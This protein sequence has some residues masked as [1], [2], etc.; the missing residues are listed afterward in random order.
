MAGNLTV[1][2][3]LREYKNKVN[4]DVWFHS[5]NLSSYDSSAQVAGDEKNVN[6]ISG[7]SD[8]TLSLFLE[9][10]GAIESPTLSYIRENF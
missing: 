3:G 6:L 4:R 1:A 9:A 7:F 5:V 10:E 2:A 8:K